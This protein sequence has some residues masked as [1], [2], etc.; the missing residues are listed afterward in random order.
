MTRPY[1]ARGRSY[2]VDGRTRTVCRPTKLAAG[3]AYTADRSGHSLSDNART[4]SVRGTLAKG[5]HYHWW[6]VEHTICPCCRKKTGPL[7]LKKR[8]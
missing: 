3:M 1:K 7:R 2:V 4:L 8:R 5:G 6:R